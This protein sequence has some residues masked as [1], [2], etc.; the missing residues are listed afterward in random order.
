MQPLRF[1]MLGAGFWARYQLSAWQELEGVH[2]VAICDPNS[3]K[4]EALAKERGVPKIYTDPKTLFIQEKLDF[5]DIVT[6][7]ETHA[8][9]VHLAIEHRVPVICQKPMATSYTQAQQMVQAAHV[10]GVPFFM[11]EN[12]RWQ[13][14]FRALKYALETGRI[15]KAFR[16]RLD[17]ITG[18]PTFEMQPFLKTLDHFIIADLGS[19]ILDMARCL[20][21]EASTLYCQTARAHQDI[22]GEDAATILLRMNNVVV[23]VNLAEAETPLEHDPLFQ[24][25]VFIEADKGSLELGLDYRVRET[26]ADGTTVRRYAP[27]PLQ[28]MH[29]DYL[30][31]QSALIPCNA[32][33]LAGIQGQK[34]AE[35]TAEDN[36]KTVQLVFSAYESAHTNQVLYL[37]EQ[38]ICES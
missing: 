24:T 16:A 2:C 34:Q 9:L 21:G 7:V 12:F 33:I 11:H 28:W 5:V 13:P 25:L 23:T 8:P 1:A 18:Y 36:L 37:Q 31:V 30:L 3:G 6:P 20:F 22:R 15:G 32:D 4:A 35:T 38:P 19:H 10:T 29:P 26:T 27:K 17:C 14:P